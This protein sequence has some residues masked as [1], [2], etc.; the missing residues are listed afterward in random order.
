VQGSP[1]ALAYYNNILSTAA[2][3]PLVILTG[4][5]PAALR[6]FTSGSA[7]TFLWGAGITVSRLDLWSGRSR[8]IPR[9]KGVF[10]F[11]ISLASFL[12]IKVTSPVTHSE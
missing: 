6:V 1:V 5:G 12:S 10:G 8:L 11:L 4:E 7:G 9:C 3:L 2:L